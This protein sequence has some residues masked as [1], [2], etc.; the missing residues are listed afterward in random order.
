VI[1]ESFAIV[2]ATGGCGAV[3][4]EDLS[5]YSKPSAADRDCSAPSD[6]S[7]VWR[8]RRDCRRRWDG[9]SVITDDGSHAVPA[10]TDDHL[11]FTGPFRAVR[12]DALKVVI[13]RDCW[14]KAEPVASVDTV[15]EVD[16]READW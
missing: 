12:D 14:D 15:P 4:K 3:L 2:K 13:C 16:K 6:W 7:A 9:K 8:N 5:R 1:V 10:R 11:N